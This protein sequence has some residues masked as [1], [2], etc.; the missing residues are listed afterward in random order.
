ML[1]AWTPDV[2]NSA[3]GTLQRLP[4]IVVSPLTADDQD[5]PCIA[6]W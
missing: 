5:V 2:I 1:T 6:C 3:D 4:P